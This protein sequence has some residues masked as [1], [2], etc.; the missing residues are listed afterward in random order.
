MSP[1]FPKKERIN[2]KK[3]F[4]L[5][6][7]KGN[8][9]QDELIRLYYLKSKEERPSL[10]IAVP[11]KVIPKAVNRNLLKRRIREAYR[12]NRPEHFPYM[13]LCVY[14]TILICSYKEIEASL[15]NHFQ[16]IQSA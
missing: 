4:E 8:V 3:D 13:I 7:K 6:I 14:N 15:K 10:G 5:L 12:R 1:R 16:K 9:F 11:K 2:K